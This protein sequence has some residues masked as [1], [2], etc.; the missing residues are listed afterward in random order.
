MILICRFRLN[1]FNIFIHFFTLPLFFGG[2]FFL[3]FIFYAFYPIFF[4]VYIINSIFGSTFN[5][6]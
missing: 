3:F 6:Y 1:I 2:S 5:N 4:G